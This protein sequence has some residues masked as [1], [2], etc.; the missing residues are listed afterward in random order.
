MRVSAA[1]GEVWIEGRFMLGLGVA[2]PH[3]ALGA[4]LVPSSRSYLNQTW[5][6]SG[7]KVEPPTPNPTHARLWP[8][9]IQEVAVRAERIL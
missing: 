4:H 5:C 6:R 1:L 7:T 2:L 8:C 3:S 9:A